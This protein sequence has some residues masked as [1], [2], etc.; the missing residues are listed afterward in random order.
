MIFAPAALKNGRNDYVFNIPASGARFPRG[1]TAAG[2]SGVRVPLDPF[3]RFLRDCPVAPPSV[4]QSARPA[5]AGP[6]AAGLAVLFLAAV[7]LAYLPALWGGFL[8]DD[9]AHVTKLGLRSLHGLWRIW[10]DV[11]ATQQYYP[12]LHSAFWLEHR[13][14]GDS[15][16][17]YH[18]LNVALHA[19]AAWLLVLN[20]RRLAFPLPVLAGLIFA[21]HPVCVESVAWI[22]EQKNTLSAVFYLGSALLYLRFDEARGRGTYLAAFGLFM[23]ALLTKTVTATLPAALLVVFWWRR[24]RI[25]WRRDVLPLAPWFAAGAASGLFTAQVE[26][27]LIGAQGAD[28]SFSFVQR[29]LL[30]GKA[31]VFYA[32]KLVWPEGLSFVY[33]RWRID[34]GDGRQYLY[35]AAVLAVLAG[36]VWVARRIRGP[37]AGLLFFAGTLFPVLGF[38]NV[39]PFLFSFVADHFQYLACI[40]VIVP[41]AWGLGQLASGFPVGATGRAC[42]LFAVPVLLG[43]L[44]W[45]Q[46]RNYGDSDTL[47]RATILRNPSAWLAH[48]N[49]AVSLGSSPGGLDESIAEYEATLR[50]KPDHWAA[51]ANLASAM[52]REP[53]RSAEAIGEYEAAIRLNPGFAE[54][55]NDLGIALGRDPGRLLEAIAHVR[56]AVSLRPDYDGAMNNLGILLMRRK[57]S[58]DEAVGDFR[59]AIRIAPDNAEYRYNLANALAASPGRLDEA[60]G[61]YRAALALRPGFVEAHSNLGAA[62]DR[63]TGHGPEAVAEYEAAVRIAPGNAHVHVNLANALS[64]I[65]GRAA[66]AVAEYRVALRINP[67]DAQGHNELGVVLSD[68]PGQLPEAVLEFKE[69]VRLKPGFALAHYCLAVALYRSGAPSGEVRAHLQEALAADPGFEAAR[70]ALAQLSSQPPHAR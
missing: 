60:I 56:T 22:S 34:A 38:F 14:W 11:G 46:C 30:A 24:G 69:A 18:L 26:S 16:L 66:D 58:I 49:L 41:L 21:L 70:N 48:Y 33:P 8:W 28:F 19:T 12:L 35:L 29:L 5:S 67:D 63:A 23:M 37:L 64:R 61:E 32:G 13:L 51:H 6:G 47:N 55:H 2:R 54:A 45:R 42:L 15:V 31:I 7:V 43:V 44:T 50:L 40:G 27:A 1:K 9:D 10:T 65:P 68:I 20:L 57:G 53:G 17:G 4:V 3:W 59:A 25:D 39:Y 62:L 52:L 36:A